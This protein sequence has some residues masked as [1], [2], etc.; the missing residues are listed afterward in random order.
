MVRTYY[1]KTKHRLS[2]MDARWC[3]E[4][5]NYTLNTSGEK[6]LRGKYCMTSGCSLSRES[7]DMLKDEELMLLHYDWDWGL[8]ALHTLRIDHQLSI[9]PTINWAST[10]NWAFHLEGHLRS[11]RMSRILSI[12]EV[13]N[14]VEY[15][16]RVVIRAVFKV[17]K[18]DLPV[19]LLS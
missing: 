19:E 3:T 8:P 13:H 5:K 18:P 17:W 1:Q 12:S 11:R 9:S 14:V 4:C 7:Q 15:S 10:I 6:G 2:V 16:W